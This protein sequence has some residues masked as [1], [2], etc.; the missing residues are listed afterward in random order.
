MKPAI[1]ILIA[2]SLLSACAGSQPPAGGTSR[3]TPPVTAGFQAGAANLVE[4]VVNDRAPAEQVALVAPDGRMFPAQQ[5]LRDRV[6]ETYAPYGQPS[7]GVGVGVGSGGNVG[8]GIG[9]GIPFLLGGSSSGRDWVRT[10]ARIRVD[11]MAGYRTDWQRW[12]VLIDL[13]PGGSAGPRQLTV[14]APRPPA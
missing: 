5:I 4:V 11:D 7:V 1:L 9:I 2:V 13:G 8:T 3:A 14:P 10:T 12:I 6:D